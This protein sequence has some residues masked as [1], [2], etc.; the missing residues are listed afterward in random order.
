[1]TESI[2]CTSLSQLSTASH[3]MSCSGVFKNTFCNCLKQSAANIRSN[4]EALWVVYE[5]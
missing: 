1:M 2:A 3:V 4:N 5:A